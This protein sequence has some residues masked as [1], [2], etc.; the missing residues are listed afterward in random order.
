MRTDRPRGRALAW[1]RASLRPGGG[2]LRH[3]RR[4]P[5]PEPPSRTSRSSGSTSTA[6]SG[7]PGSAGTWNLRHGRTPVPGS[8][9]L[10]TSRPCTQFPDFPMPDDWPDYPRH[11]QL[12]TYLE[13]YADHFGLREHIWFGTQVVGSTRS[14]RS[15]P[16]VGSGH[17]DVTDP[18]S[19]RR[20]RPGAAVR[21]GRRRQRPHVNAGPAG[22]P[23]RAG[24]LPG[25]VMHSS[26]Y[27]DAAQLRGKRVLVVGAGNA[28]CESRL[29]TRRR[30][31]P[32]AGIPA[33]G[34]TGTPRST[35][36][37]GPGT[38]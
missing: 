27:Q 26:D 1:R 6:T 4:G 35:S 20:G 33:A 32:P 31:P 16:G 14:S 38:R 11:A 2:G 17:W 10:I 3:R 23:T 18:G 12:L 25:Q 5:W 7:R 30:P 15:G 21:G 13:R 19:A 37:A 8:T 24:G 29:S 9:H 22:I 28:G 36:S 34:A